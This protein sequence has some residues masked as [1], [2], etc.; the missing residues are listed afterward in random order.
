MDP[1]VKTAGKWVGS[2]GA[3]LLI[4]VGL[5]LGAVLSVYLLGWVIE[6]IG[7]IFD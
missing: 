7:I 4:A 6:L 3:V 2:A 1:A 5:Y